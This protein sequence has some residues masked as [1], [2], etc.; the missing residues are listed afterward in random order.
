MGY[1]G[2]CMAYFG[3]QWPI[4]VGYLAL[5]EALLRHSFRFKGSFGNVLEWN[6]GRRVQNT[7]PSAGTLKLENTQELGTP[8]I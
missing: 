2:S 4:I 8:N 1:F 5:Q 3:V 6:G 7:S